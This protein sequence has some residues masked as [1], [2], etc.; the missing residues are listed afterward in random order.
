MLFLGQV[1]PRT[2]YITPSPY[3]SA[4]TATSRHYIGGQRHKKSL[5]FAEDERLPDKV[6]SDVLGRRKFENRFILQNNQRSWS[7]WSSFSRSSSSSVVRRNLRIRA[8]SDNSN[9]NS[10]ATVA[11]QFDTIKGGCQKEN[12]TSIPST[13]MSNH[14]FI[15]LGTTST[16]TTTSTA[17][18][19][20]TTTA[21][22]T[23]K[24][25]TNGFSFRNIRKHQN[26]IKEE[27]KR[28][29]ESKLNNN[30]NNNRRIDI[31]EEFDALD[32]DTNSDE[33]E[34]DTSTVMTVPTE[35]EEESVSDLVDPFSV[36]QNS[37]I[38]KSDS[39]KSIS[40][41]RHEE[42]QLSLSL[43]V[44]VNN[45]RKELLKLKAILESKPP[46]K[47]ILKKIKTIKKVKTTTP[48]PQTPTKPTTTTRKPVKKTKN[49]D[50]YPRIWDGP[51]PNCA[52]DG[53]GGC[54]GGFD[55]YYESGDTETF[56]LAQTSNRRIDIDESLP[57]LNRLDDTELFDK[58][59]LL[60]GKNIKDKI[61][62]HLRQKELKKKLGSTFKL[63]ASSVRPVVIQS[64][65]K[66][67]GDS[68]TRNEQKTLEKIASED[69][70]IYSVDEWLKMG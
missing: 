38:L 56:R 18:S 41:L 44:E 3:S 57:G 10:T 43:E 26:K 34:K 55:D 19:S 4:A 12:I 2:I 58:S 1:K 40:D 21:A 48:R 22:S 17:T 52:W 37:Q 5:S 30:N 53:P 16:T 66:H 54:G 50:E 65:M 39:Q 27:I 63:T 42:E 62:E 13:T 7:G 32:F 68:K 64:L 36:L 67:S 11:C 29:V 61:K 70:K 6:V 35:K 49:Y 46:K 33:N 28:L 15:R 24:L 60:P 25:T 31:E 14:K 8:N 47:K 20:M 9:R 23:K 59:K 51:Q 45:L 69:Y